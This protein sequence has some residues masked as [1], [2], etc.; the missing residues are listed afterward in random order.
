MKKLISLFLL[1]IAVCLLQNSSLLSQ[2]PKAANMECKLIVE[3]KNLAIGEVPSGRVEIKNISKQEIVIT[4][5]TS[6]WEFLDLEVADPT[7]KV[8]SDGK[9]GDRFSPS[10]IIA[11]RIV[12]LRPGDVFTRAVDVFGSSKETDRMTPGIYRVVAVFGYNEVLA[13]SDPVMLNLGTK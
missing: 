13:K 8:I 3:N 11:E 10:T 1:L 7:G 4:Y 2:T 5:N 9:Y 6:P 12:T